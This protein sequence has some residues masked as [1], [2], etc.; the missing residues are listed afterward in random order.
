MRIHTLEELDQQLD[1]SIT[2]RLRELTQ[3][4]LLIER[5]QN[6]S[7]VLN[8]YIRAGITLLY[9]HWEGFIKEASLAYLNF[10]SMQRLSYDQLAPNFIAIALKSKLNEADRVSDPLIHKKVVEFFLFKLSERSRIPRSSDT[11]NTMSNLKSDV[12]K[13]IV[14]S[15]GLD[16]RAEYQMRER[17]ID[18]RLLKTRNEVAH[19]EYIN[20]GFS[21]FI[22]LHEK[23]IELI[24]LFRD[25]VSNAAVLE[26]Y[27]CLRQPDTS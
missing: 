25:Q 7:L 15:L 27:K 10:V 17:L 11:I 13:K 26:K 6:S 4:K 5:N 2:W 9:A 21:D 24:R 19:G 3:I 8:C 12:F 20:I 1:Q 22:E 16:Y 14:H 18:I 23:V